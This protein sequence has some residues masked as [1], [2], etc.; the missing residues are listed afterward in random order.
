LHPEEDAERAGVERALVF[1]S[2]GLGSRLIARM[3]AGG[4]PMTASTQLYRSADACRL[5]DA[6]A[7]TEAAV[8]PGPEFR[9]RLEQE[10]VGASTGRRAPGT[11]PD[12]LL[13]F[14][15]DGKASPRCV[16]EINRD[17]RGTLQFAPYLYLNDPALAGPIVWAREV[18]A[19]DVALARRYA[20]RPVYRYRGPQRDGANPFVLLAER[21]E[22]WD[23]QSDDV[24]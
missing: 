12:A 15:D 7:V 17:R 22:L 13:R 9:A 5:T 8:A 11:T 1:I 16:A 4:V 2:D 23:G 10:L 19:A 3:W 14:P 6:L 18:G 21:G 24:R 20:D